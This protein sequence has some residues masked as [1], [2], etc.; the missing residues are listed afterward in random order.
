MSNFNFEASISEGIQKADIAEIN[1]NE[2]RT[3]F[4]E[5]AN[6][7]LRMSKNKIYSKI[8]EK[9]RRISTNSRNPFLA[10]TASLI[11]N[12]TYEYY[13]ALVLTNGVN[14]YVIA[15]IIENE[16]GY[17]LRIKINDNTSAYSDKDSLIEGLS[18]LVSR[19]EVGKYYKL[20]LSDNL[21]Q[22]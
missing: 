18:Y 9:Q 8:K 11:N 6:S 3:I 2:I 1:K 10:T 17:P 4:E 16:D 22:N 21:E 5:F 7:F 12:L 13:T 14:E 15:E 19:T 20:L